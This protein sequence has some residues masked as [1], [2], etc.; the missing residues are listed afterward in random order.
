MFFFCRWVS[1][2]KF[3]PGDRASGLGGAYTAVADEPSGAYYNPAGLAFAVG[4][5]L[6]VS[7]NAYHISQTVYQNVLPKTT[8]GADDWTLRSSKLIPNFLE[9]QENLVLGQLLSLMLSLML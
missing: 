6:S 1:L 2:Q 4:N 3:F 9:L 5:E 8:G 7:V